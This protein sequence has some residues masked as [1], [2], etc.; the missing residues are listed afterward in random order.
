MTEE[1][2]NLIIEALITLS[3]ETDVGA[4]S[5]VDALVGECWNEEDGSYIKHELADD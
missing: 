1:K 3:A 4:S 5:I 2:L